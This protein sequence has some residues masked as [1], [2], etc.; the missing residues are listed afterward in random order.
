M[1]DWPKTNGALF[2]KKTFRGTNEESMRNSASLST[3]LRVPKLFCL[4]HLSSVA[5]LTV[6]YFLARDCM[7]HVYE[8]LLMREST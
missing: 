8:G 1:K 5:S 4:R 6:I 3:R 7:N 2:L